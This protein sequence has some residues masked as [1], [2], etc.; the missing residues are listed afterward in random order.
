M[1]CPGA[2]VRDSDSRLPAKKDSARRRLFFLF[3]LLPDRRDRDR[4]EDVDEE[5]VEK[6]VATPDRPLEAGREDRS[7]IVHNNSH[8]NALP[9]A[10]WPPVRG[11]RKQGSSVTTVKQDEQECKNSLQ[12]ETSGDGRRSG[13]IMSC[14][15]GNHISQLRRQVLFFI[16]LRTKQQTHD[17]MYT[18]TWSHAASALS[19]R[20]GE[21]GEVSDGW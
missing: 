9:F 16:S 3:L 5:S 20:D 14:G 11:E 1:G 15:N 13:C 21:V 8:P 6:E 7:S 12:P 10:R 19:C 18:L 2:V 4:E 17:W